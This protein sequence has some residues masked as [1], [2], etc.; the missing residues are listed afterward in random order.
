MDQLMKLLQMSMVSQQNQG[1]GRSDDIPALLS[2]GEYVIPADV[3][4]TLGEGSNDAG[5]SILDTLMELL[6]GM[7]TPKE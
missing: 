5:A 1:T 4:A 3:V 7:N 2:E 6:R